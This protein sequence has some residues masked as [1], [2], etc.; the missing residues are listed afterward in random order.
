V[1]RQRVADAGARG[2]NT[3]QLLKF[4]FPL[5]VVNVADEAMLPKQSRGQVYVRLVL[6]PTGKKTALPW[7][8]SFPNR[9]PEWSAL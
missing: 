1:S 4:E 8:G 6:S 7:P 5:T 3:S 2:A 9:A